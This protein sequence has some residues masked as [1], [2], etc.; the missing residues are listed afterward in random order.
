MLKA[1]D[2]K[3][4]VP[5]RYGKVLF[6][7]AAAAGKSNFF[8]LLMKENFQPLHIST[9]VLKPQQVTVAMKA[10]ISSNDNEVEFNIMNI[11]DEILQLESYLPKNYSTPKA[12]LQQNIFQAP[13]LYHVHT[14]PIDNLPKKYTDSKSLFQKSSQKV[15]LQYNKDK[16]PAYSSKLALANIKTEPK[17]LYS[18]KPGAVWDILTFMDTG[19]QPQFI[20]MLPA[21]N[22]FAMITF[23]VHKME[24]DGQNSL[25]KIVKVQYGNEK[26]EISYKPHPHKYTY[27]QLIETLISYASNILPADTKFLD[28]VKIESAKYENT[29]SILLVG[30]HSGNDQ[31]S[32]NEIKK[33]DEEFTKAVK[34]S[35]VNHIK[36][37]LNK[38]YN[39]L[40]PVDNQ[41]QCKNSMLPAIK[42]DTKRYTIPSRL[43][44]YIKNFLDKQN[45]I[46]V[47][48][49]WLLLELEIRKV[50]QQRNCNLMSLDH[51][52]KLARERKLGYNGEFGDDVKIDA[53]QFIKQGLRFHHSFGVLLYFE[54]VEGM[55]K[56]VITNHQWLFNKLSKIVEYSFTCDTLEEMED[57]K[58]GIFKKTLLGSECLDI[59]KDFEDSNIDIKSVEPI[60]AFLKLLEHLRIAA[61][62]NENA[63]NY[64]MPCILDSYELTDLK[65]RVPE[66]KTNDTEPL[67][68]QYISTDNKTYAFPRGVF[69]FLVVE[70]MVAM[71]WSP[72]RQ[73]YVNLITL[74]KK[75]TVHYITLIDRIF[76]LEVHV[77]YKKDND[78]HDEVREVITKALD[79][80]G[81]KLKI[82]CNL[83]HGFSCP[84]KLIEEMHISYL[85]IDNNNHSWCK[86]KSV[87]DLTD[88]HRLWLKTYFKVCMYN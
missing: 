4:S 86:K 12:P 10:V 50:C 37:Y 74:F 5:I 69:C 66:Y 18:R 1:R 62:S 56:L 22:S 64:F 21:V 54:D 32:E 49:K 41:K 71:K 8:N 11:D 57:L 36:P 45:K 24:T 28:K 77:T 39:F 59:N 76:C 16:S 70:L 84:C 2:A 46:H 80:V 83:C 47:P 13:S 87:I 31:L 42:C 51:I 68:I 43:R 73:A 78:I 29:K 20:S 38:S 27:L 58:N 81:K 33:V 60:N 61:P 35:G 65:V 55:Q 40:V 9:E 85:T 79:S 82:D 48:I 15:G 17:N 53:N 7:G 6:C 14:C 26:G 52:L 63:I 88:S 44:T 3:Y 75:D 23:I 67:F 30:T 25:N 72:Y 34:I 19:G